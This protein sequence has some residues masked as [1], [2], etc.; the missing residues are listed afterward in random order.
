MDYDQALSYIH[1]C[2]KFGT[3]LGL[4]RIREILRRL[5]NPQ[6][7]FRAVHIAGTNGKGSTAAMLDSVLQ[8][9]GYKSGRYTSPHLSSYRERF[10][11]NGEMI[12]KNQL[13]AVITQIGPVLEA[14]ERDGFGAPTE[15]EVGTAIAFTHFAQEQ[16]E[17][18]VI[19]VGMG[20]RLDATN[21]LTPVL[22]I[23]T[24]LALDHQQYLGDTLEQI[25]FE[26]AGI[27][28]PG[29]PVVIGIQEP[30]IEKYLGEIA[31]LRQAPCRRASELELRDLVIGETGTSGTFLGTNFGPLKL[32]L[33]LIGRH[34]ALNCLNVLAGVEVLNTAGI[35]INPDQLRS[36]LAGSV[37]PS[38]MER[39]EMFAPVKLYLD[40]AHN[41]DGAQTL[42]VTMNILYPKEKASL[43]VG[44]LN[45]RPLEELAR[46]FSGF[47]S[48]VITT[49]V[50]DPKSSDPVKLAQIFEGY[51]VPAV[52]EP[53]PCRALDRLIA[54]GN[55]LAV[56]T[57]SLYLTG[58]LRGFILHTGD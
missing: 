46:I 28:K 54:T 34:Q 47:A 5:G 55:Q 21:V 38:R 48:N 3:K 43:L 37:W 18:A 33:K 50:P 1:E 10:T 27:I 57:G 41:P 42:A 8:A 2:S 19:E 45:N 32:D 22:S 26:K 51:G 53:D 9:A 6:E 29:V 11:V 14:V 58:Y 15:F 39:L 56:V 31:A 30:Q 49:S 23:I 25:A 24:H 12:S 16:V 20:G 40:G 13:A 44:I 17:L 7:H 35:S 52:S 4:E 36:G